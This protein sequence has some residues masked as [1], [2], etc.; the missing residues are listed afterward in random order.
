MRSAFVINKLK[1]MQKLGGYIRNRM[2]DYLRLLIIDLKIQKQLFIN[3][4]VCLAIFSVFL[5]LSLIFLGIAVIIT[6]IDTPY[7]VTAAWCVF[8][9]HILLLFV[10]LF[11]YFKNRSSSPLFCEM[12][13]ELKQDINM[14]KELL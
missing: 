12:E 2:M 3:R 10:S 14:M 8:C 4:M 7:L 1:H 5:F 11:L 13:E 9:V 6:F